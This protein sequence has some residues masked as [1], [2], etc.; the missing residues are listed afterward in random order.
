M[1]FVQNQELAPFKVVAH[2]YA[3]DSDNRMHADDTAAE[4]GFAGGLVPGVALYAYMTSSIVE[5]LGRNWLSRGSAKV[6]FLKPVYHEEAIWVRGK[7]ASVEPLG[8]TVEL[9]KVD[10]ELCAVAEAFARGEHDSPVAAQY[11][12]RLMPPKDDR[13]VASLE[14]LA[15]GT[16]LGTYTETFD[17]AA[18]ADGFIEDVNEPLPLYRLE[19]GPCHPAYYL[20]LANEILMGNVVLGPWIHAGSDVQHFAMPENG[21]PLS[22]RGTVA[23]A[24]EKKGHEFVVL[25]LALFGVVGRALAWIRHTAIINPRKSA[26]G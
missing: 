12:E 24:Y 7:I 9:S 5:S 8:L 6:R 25:D 18:L 2:N 26:S 17:R 23:E 1:G 11:P 3:T 14:A 15:P 13:P 4:Y 16:L 22:V 20:A 21:E 19:D 10:G